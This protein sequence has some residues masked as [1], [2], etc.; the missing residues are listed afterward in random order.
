MSFSWKQSSNF[1][2][3]NKQR[4]LDK[5]DIAKKLILLKQRLWEKDMISVTNSVELH[6]TY[7]FEDHIDP[8]NPLGTSIN[9]TETD[10]T[11]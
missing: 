8:I 3:F 6:N 5:T 10:V 7:A 9:V 4:Y 1:P 11:T 2:G